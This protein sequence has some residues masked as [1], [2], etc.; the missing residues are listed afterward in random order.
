MKGVEA[1]WNHWV[2]L[3]GTGSPFSFLG[4][5]ESKDD[6]A[7]K[8]GEQDNAGD[9]GDGDEGEQGDGDKGEQGDG[10]KGEQ[11]DGDEAADEDKGGEVEV[12]D[13]ENNRAPTHHHAFEEDEGIP[14]PS[15][16]TTPAE[17]SVLLQQLAPDTLLGRI[18]GKLVKL[19]D[20]LEVSSIPV[21]QFF[22]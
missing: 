1:Y 2:L 21:I 16:C 5:D 4:V 14:L 6:E 20:V 8:D 10:D 17:R 22:P 3:A 18:F 7:S 9:G 11:G 13:E 15:Q 12:D 19:V